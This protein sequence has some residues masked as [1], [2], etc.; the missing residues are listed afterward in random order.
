M[1]NLCH[2]FDLPE[3]SNNPVPEKDLK[4]ATAQ[5]QQRKGAKQTAKATTQVKKSGPKK[6]E[7]VK[8]PGPGS[9]AKNVPNDDKKTKGEECTVEVTWSWP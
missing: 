1:K 4:I 3:P 2:S 7:I 5:A 8:K 6:K 9:D